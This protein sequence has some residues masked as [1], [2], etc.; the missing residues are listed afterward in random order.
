MLELILCKTIYMFFCFCVIVIKTR[1]H[2]DWMVI[3]MFATLFDKL[4][5]WTK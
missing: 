1:K 4:W 2:I 3:I 5:N